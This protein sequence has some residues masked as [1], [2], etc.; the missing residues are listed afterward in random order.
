MLCWAPG[1]GKERTC[2]L[3][4]SVVPALGRTPSYGMGTP[5]PEPSG[6]DLRHRGARRN[7]LR[8]VELREDSLEV[9][10]GLVRVRGQS[11]GRLVRV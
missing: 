8:D 2:A 10:K 5:L 3:A 1:W 11:L 6:G 9:F 7:V 4:S